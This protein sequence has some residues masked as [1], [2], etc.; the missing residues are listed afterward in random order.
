[1]GSSFCGVA[2]SDAMSAVSSAIIASETSSRPLLPTSV[3][4]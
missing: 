2:L 3:S 4:A 1:V